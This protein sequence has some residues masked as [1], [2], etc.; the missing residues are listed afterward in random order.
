M[1]TI[2]K[3]WNRKNYEQS[4][5]TV[6]TDNLIKVQLVKSRLN[7]KENLNYKNPK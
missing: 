3:K 5:R 4:C 1:Y 7:R 6:I 2:F